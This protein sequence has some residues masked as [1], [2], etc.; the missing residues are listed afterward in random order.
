LAKI[1]YNFD[2]ELH[3]D[4]AQWMEGQQIYFMWIKPELK[5][6]VKRRAE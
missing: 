2:F 1:L 6:V 3:E 4:S 5:V